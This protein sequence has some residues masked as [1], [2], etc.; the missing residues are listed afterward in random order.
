M[1]R[2]GLT[3]AEAAGVA[4]DVVCDTF[5]RIGRIFYCVYLLASGVREHLLESIDQIGE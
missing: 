3:V 2:N 4:R 1:N 5:R